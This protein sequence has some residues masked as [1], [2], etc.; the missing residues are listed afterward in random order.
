MLL[1]RDSYNELK[2]CVDLVSIHRVDTTALCSV[3]GSSGPVRQFLLAE[4]IDIDA[5]EDQDAILILQW[6]ALTQRAANYS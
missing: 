6:V 2:L 4:E 1:I 5:E 3:E